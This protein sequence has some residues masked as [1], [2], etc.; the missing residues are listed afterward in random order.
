MK[1]KNIIII[2]IVLAILLIVVGVFAFLNAGNILEKKNLEE[3]K[4]ISIKSEGIEIRKVDLAFISS[5]GEEDFSAIMDTSDSEPKKHY[6][7]GVLLKNV[8]QKSGI[9]IDD[10]AMLTVKAIDGYVVAFKK[11]E[12]AD[13]DNIYIAYKEDGKDLG[14]KSSGGRGPYQII[15]RKDQFSMRWCKFVVEIELSKK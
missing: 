5:A 11:E 10:Y 1:K 6:Y 12:V 3:S 9:N 7:T 2:S 8:L 13:D 4:T 15:V 14:T